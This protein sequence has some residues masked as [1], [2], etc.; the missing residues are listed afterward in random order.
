MKKLSILTLLTLLSFF[1]TS[2]ME[3]QEMLNKMIGGIFSAIVCIPLFILFGK[4][5]S[6]KR[7]LKEESINLA[8]EKCKNEEYEKA[9]EIL[10]NIEKTIKNEDDRIFLLVADKIKGVSLFY[11][12]QIDKSKQILL[13]TTKLY[14]EKFSSNLKFKEFIAEAY[15]F[16]SAIYFQENNLIEAQK[17]KRKALELDSSLSEYKFDKEIVGFENI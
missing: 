2:C 14:E 6:K 16:L 12:G 13:K 1:L 3:N 4:L 17:N 7:N 5:T 8:L 15:L 11:S 9:I 10:D